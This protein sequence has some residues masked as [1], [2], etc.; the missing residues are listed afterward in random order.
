[1]SPGRLRIALGKRDHVGVVFDAER[2]GAEFFRCGD[3]DLAVAGAQ[4]DH[5]V[6]RL[7]LRH[8]QHAFDDLVRRRDPYHVLALLADVGFEV[9]L[10][11]VSGGR[12]YEQNGSERRQDAL[13]N[14]TKHIVLFLFEWEFG[15]RKANRTTARAKSIPYLTAP[16][17]RDRRGASARRAAASRAPSATSL[18]C[19]PR[20]TSARSCP[21]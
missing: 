11:G 13:R 2:A 1:Q 6:L 20:R 4:I 12:R 21:R 15:V 5:I 14:C 17:R 8:V 10:L 18:S 3:C 19:G 7:R 9:L 16:R